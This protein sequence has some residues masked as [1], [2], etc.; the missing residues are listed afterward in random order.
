MKSEDYAKPDVEDGEGNERKWEIEEAARTLLKAEE[1]RSDAGLMEKVG[2]L[3]E[4]KRGHAESAV[5]SFAQLKKL[6]NKKT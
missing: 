2:P 1:I 6:A 4:K 5:K 3:L